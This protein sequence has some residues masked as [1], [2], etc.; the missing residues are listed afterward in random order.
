MLKTFMKSVRP[1]FLR[2]RDRDNYKESTASR[3]QSPKQVIILIFIPLIFSF[4]IFPASITDCFL[5]P[6]FS[7]LRN[8]KKFRISVDSLGHKDSSASLFRLLNKVN[9]C[10]SGFVLGWAIRILRGVTTFFSFFLFPFHGDIKRV[11]WRL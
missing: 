6:T 3:P 7:H 1:T 5:F 4:P 10:S 11:L 8:L 2:P 9:S